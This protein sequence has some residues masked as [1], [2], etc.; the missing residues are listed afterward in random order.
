MADEELAGV[1][2]DAVVQNAKLAGLQKR[3]GNAAESEESDKPPAKKPKTE[4]DPL[5]LTIVGLKWA[6]ATAV[7]GEK[8]KLVREPDN[9]YDPNAIK[10]VNSSGVGVGHISKESAASLART[11]DNMSAKLAPKALVFVVEGTVTGC[12]DGYK[13]PVQVVFKQLSAHGGKVVIEPD[14]KAAS[15][16]QDSKSAAAPAAPAPKR[17]AKCGAC[18]LEGHNRRSATADNCPAFN[19]PNEV[20]KR[21]KS[22]EKA[23]AKK[24]EKAEA[25]KLEPVQA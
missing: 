13:Q 18:G 25:K 8:V 22:L 17:K 14:S 4:M 11:M 24:L 23:E 16:P 2:L 1:D 6:S 15:A 9:K 10:V 7:S 20:E 5:P 19:D 3:D 12:G 21:R